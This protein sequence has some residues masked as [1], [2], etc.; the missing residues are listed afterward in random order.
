M[1]TLIIREATSADVTTLA[2]LHVTTFNETH[3]PMLM[4]GP[5]Y[6]LAQFCDPSTRGRRGP[7]DARI[8]PGGTARAPRPRVVSLLVRPS[9]LAW[10]DPS[11]FPPH[12]T[13]AQR[14]RRPRPEPAPAETAP[15]PPFAAKASA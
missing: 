9:K 7:L 2:R 11:P 14:C 12:A 8:R 1:Q 4:D 15:T 10:L 5:S 3:A 6:P 13:V